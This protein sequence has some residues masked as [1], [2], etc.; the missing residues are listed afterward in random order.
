MLLGSVEVPVGQVSRRFSNI[1]ETLPN[2]LSILHARL[3]F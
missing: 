2:E 1:F 3:E